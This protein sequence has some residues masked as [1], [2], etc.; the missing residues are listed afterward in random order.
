[1]KAITRI[2]CMVSSLVLWGIAIWALTVPE[3]DMIQ[4]L[5]LLAAGVTLFV[6]M[7]EVSLF[8]LDPELRPH[9]NAKNI[10][11]TLLLGA[12]HFLPLYKSTKGKL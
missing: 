11:L 6:H 12:F 8:Y 4:W 1:M 7:V 9:A 2:V 5:I 3:K 10:A